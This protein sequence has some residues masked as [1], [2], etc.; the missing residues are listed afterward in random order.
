MSVLVAVV[1][2]YGLITVL[3][4]KE[5]STPNTDGVS[6]PNGAGAIGLG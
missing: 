4:L 5:P 2:V 1:L 3:I 6:G